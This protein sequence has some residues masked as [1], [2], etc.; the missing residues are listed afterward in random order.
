[1]FQPRENRI[2]LKDLVAK[3]T[4]LAPCVFDCM[5][6]RVAEICGFK[7][8]LLS[9]GEI[10]EVYSAFHRNR[11]DLSENEYIEMMFDECS[12]EELQSLR[13]WEFN[14]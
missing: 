10:E 11:T 6:A 2:W 14:D 13:Y 3:E 5:S 9:G 12:E 7:A 1:M 4:I 8:I